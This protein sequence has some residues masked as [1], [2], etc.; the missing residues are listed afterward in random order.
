MIVFYYTMIAFYY[1]MIAFYYTMIGILSCMAYIP[2][3]IYFCPKQPNKS[4]S[5]VADTGFN[6]NRFGIFR[7]IK[8]QTDVK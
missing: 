2:Y 3:W 8:G 4:G 5:H 6:E 1:T 7:G